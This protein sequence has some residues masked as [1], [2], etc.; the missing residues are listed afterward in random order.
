MICT[1]KRMR[2]C[3]ALLIV[4]LMVIWGN[5]LLPGW[6]SQGISDWAKGLL[7]ALL[8]LADDRT[9][10]M[11]NWGLIIRKMAHF[12]E[13]TALGVLLSWRMGMQGKRKWISFALGAGA[14]WVDE[15]IQR[16]VPGRSSQWT[17]V[18]LDCCGVLFGILLLYIGHRYLWRR[19]KPKKEK[20][21]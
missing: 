20:K 3:G 7:K 4:N 9:D 12:S 17:D 11:L 5:S 14:A 8:C 18:A 10:E 16:F 13:F 15:T 19:K 2:L 6:I 1:E 21:Q